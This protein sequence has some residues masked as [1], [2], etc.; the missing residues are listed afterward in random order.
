MGKRRETTPL[1]P[2]PPFHAPLA[3]LAGWLGELKRELGCGGAV[4]GAALVPLGDLRQRVAAA[5]AARGVGR[6]TTG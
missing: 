5:L 4:E 1:P 3:G 2:V 6:I